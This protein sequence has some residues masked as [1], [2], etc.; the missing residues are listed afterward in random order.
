M[1]R[2]KVIHSIP[3]IDLHSLSFKDTL[4]PSLLIY[5]ILDKFLAPLLLKSFTE[6]VIIV[7]RGLNSKRHIKGQ[8]ILRFYTCE[9]LKTLGLSYVYDPEKGTIKVSL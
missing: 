3:L 2:K 5:P 1:P 7:G 9:Y 8:P 4:E 6:A